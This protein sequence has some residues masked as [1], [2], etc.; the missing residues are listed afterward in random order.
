MFRQAVPEGAE[1]WI[2]DSM[3]RSSRHV[4]QVLKVLG[5]WHLDPAI[6]KAARKAARRARRA[7]RRAR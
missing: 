7:R 3:S 5:R 4:V 2:I 6:A 1:M